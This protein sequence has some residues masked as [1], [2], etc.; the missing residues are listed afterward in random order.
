MN[1]KAK[2]LSFIRRGPKRKEI[3]LQ[4]NKNRVTAIDLVKITK[5]YKSHVSRALN[6]LKIKKLIKCEN[7]KDRAFRYYSI[8]QKGSKILKELRLF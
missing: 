6:E 3:L 1:V 8:T 4:L 7:P 2:T 5:M